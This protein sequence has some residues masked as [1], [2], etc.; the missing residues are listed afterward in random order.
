MN[1]INNGKLDSIISDIDMPK[2]GFYPS[3]LINIARNNW[4]DNQNVLN[5]DAENIQREA[6]GVYMNS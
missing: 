5:T 1:N 4:Y 3:I 6:Y 2:Q